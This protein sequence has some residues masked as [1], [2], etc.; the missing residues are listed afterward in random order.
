MKRRAQEIIHKQLEGLTLEEKLK[1]WQERDEA[2]RRSQEA[3]TTSLTIIPPL[4][5]LMRTF[6]AVYYNHP[7]LRDWH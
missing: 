6:L 4:R 2:Y 1:Y 5:G 3:L 7:S